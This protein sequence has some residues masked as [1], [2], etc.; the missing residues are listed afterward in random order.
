MRDNELYYYP[1]FI[2]KKI[3]PSKMVSRFIIADNNIYSFTDFAFSENRNFEGS[4]L[5]KKAI[6]LYLLKER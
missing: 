3:L 5:K 1:N 4:Y 2:Y 6:L